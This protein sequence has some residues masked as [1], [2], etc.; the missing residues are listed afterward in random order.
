MAGYN[1]TPRAVPQVDT[2]YR[3]IKTRIPVPESLPILKQLAA[4]E[5][6]SMHGQPPVVWDRAEGI[7]IYDRWGNMWIDW[8]CGV[9]VTNAGHG[10]RE[11]RAALQELIDKPLLATYVFPHEPR[12]LLTSMLKELAPKKTDYRVFL[13]STGSEATEN[14]IK[15]ARTYGVSKGGQRKHVLVGFDGAFHGRTL[16]AQ[17]AGGMLAENI[18]LRALC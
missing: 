16:G 2:R 11:I 6:R 18:R 12:T 7:N 8:S 5:P 15:L 1:L 17:L 3:R 9:L 13:L 10:R 4:S 14:A